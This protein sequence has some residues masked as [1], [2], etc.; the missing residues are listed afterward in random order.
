MVPQYFAHDRLNYKGLDQ[1][2]TVGVD[3]SVCEGLRVKTTPQVSSAGT[4]ST[5]YWVH[6]L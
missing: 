2:Q 5:G 3:K 6:Y 1:T 4:L